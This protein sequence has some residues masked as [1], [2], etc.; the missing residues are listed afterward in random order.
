MRFRDVIA[1]ALASL[2]A[3]QTKDVRA[4][5][6]CFHP[7]NQSGTV[8]TDHRM[9]FSISQVQTTLY[10]EIKYSGS[11]KDFAWVLPVHGEV[12]VGLSS[13]VVFS[14]LEQQTQ[15]NIVA[16]T[17]SCPVSS[18]PCGPGSASL[19]GGFFGGG[20]AGGG[21]GGFGGGVTVVSQQTIGPYATVQLKST[22]PNALNAW[23]KANGYDIPADVQPII[24]A[25]VTE[26]F[27]F[28]AL[29]LAPG[30]GVQAMRPVRVTAPGAGL[31]LPLRMVAAGTGAT[32][33]ITLWVIADGDTSRRISSFSRSLRPSS[34]GTGRSAEATTRRCN[35]R[36][37]PRSTTRPGRSKAPSA[38][39]RSRSRTRYCKRRTT[40]CRSS[41][42]TAG[43][44][45]RLLNRSSKTS[46]CCS[47]R[48]MCRRAS[49]GCAPTWPT[50]RLQ[51][52]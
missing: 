29:K 18:C 26:G 50:P 42:E 2:F 16:P 9:I 8:V 46:G 15:T 33:G 20:G 34:R 37:R 43:R 32:V 25:Y 23:L 39:R 47:R 21:F 36:R 31:S 41:E 4:C 28:L 5:G 10:D 35:L 38:S 3:A 19:G 1:V 48:A 49:R 52:I 17:L 14:V 24:A 7:P 40:T 51:P 22:D 27:D 30:L 12:T 6:G 13:D 11:P 45:R 44:A